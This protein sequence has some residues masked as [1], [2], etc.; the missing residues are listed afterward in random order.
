MASSWTFAAPRTIITVMIFWVSD[1]RQTSITIVSGDH[2]EGF[3]LLPRMKAKFA[4]TEAPTL[5]HFVPIVC[6]WRFVGRTSRVVQ[7]FQQVFLKNYHM[8]NLTSRHIEN[9]KGPG[10]E[11]NI[12]PRMQTADQRFF[13]KTSVRKSSWEILKCSDRF[14]RWRRKQTKGKDNFC[15]VLFVA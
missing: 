15:F 10:E 9:N 5:H 11:K 7:T 14:P 12:S 2:Q 8:Y 4:A 3:G 6:R 1:D 13:K